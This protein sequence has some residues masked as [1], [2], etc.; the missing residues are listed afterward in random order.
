MNEQ[1]SLTMFLKDKLFLQFSGVY[2]VIAG[3]SIA[4]EKIWRVIQVSVCNEG[5]R[6]SHWCSWYIIPILYKLLLVP[7]DVFTR[8]YNS[9][10]SFSLNYGFIMGY[11]EF[12]IL[13]AILF[14]FI[15]A[16]PRF[17]WRLCFA[18]FLIQVFLNVLLMIIVNP[19]MDL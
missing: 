16:H 11:F 19:P 17:R 7:C 8:C 2:L 3:V 15:K 4:L 18:L 13:L 9:W 12:V 10:E 14:K 1:N 6:L 5:G